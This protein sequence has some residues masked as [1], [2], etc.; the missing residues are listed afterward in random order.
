MGAPRIAASATATP[1]W[2]TIRPTLLQLSGYDGQ[3]AGFFSNSQIDGALP[4]PGSRDLHAER[5]HRPAQR[6]VRARRHRDR[7]RRGARVL[8]RAGWTTGDVDFIATT[9]CTGRLC[10]SLDARLIN[11]LALKPSVQRVHVGDTGCASAMVAL[12]QAHNH[13]RAFPDHRAVV[14]AVELCSTAYYDDDRLESAVA[15]AIFA[16]GAGA[17]ALASD[18]DGPEI[19]AHRTIFRPEHL[20][21][22]GFEYPGGRPRVVL[23]KEVRR[24]GAAMM[25]EMAEALLAGHGLKQE[26]IRHFVLH[27]AGRRVID[28]AQKLMGL[29]ESAI[30]HSRHV[31]R[32][33]GNMSSATVLFV[34]DE[35]L[36][37][38]RD[39]AGRVGP[40]D[41]ARGRG[42]P[43]R[44]RCS[45]GS[46][47]ALDAASACR[48]RGRDARRAG[49]VRR[50]AGVPR[51]PRPPQRALRWA[52][53]H[54]PPRQ[55]AR[56]AAAAGRTLTV[57]DVGTGGG[58]VPR[59]LVRWARRM[60]RPIRVFAL[61]RDAAPCA[62]DAGSV[63]AYPEIV[64]LQGDARR[65]PDA[66][67]VGR[68]D[69]L[70]R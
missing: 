13:L 56:R 43:R 35:L 28:Q 32:H 40:D 65:L 53:S 61:D 69:H 5:E 66:A 14:V 45:A 44:A 52:L 2:H 46:H 50:S 26:D 11:T 48:G 23:S 34:L 55:A 7:H 6:S 25:K 57:L 12:Q 18:G 22:M 17:L 63:R 38:G 54:A 24:I 36:R 64:V 3:R 62:R 30:A 10:P 37:S 27:S 8:E 49:A 1:P 41:R 39:G 19:A 4:L 70:R 29:D 59:E 60:G 31:L 16:D 67:R 9:T 21:A 58:D 51:R 15:H 33:F 68:R 47:G 42:S 20:S